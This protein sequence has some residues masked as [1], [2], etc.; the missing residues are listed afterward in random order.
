[1]RH[2]VV[3]ILAFFISVS[4]EAKASGGSK[5]S[6]GS[7]FSKLVRGLTRFGLGYGFTQ[8][9]EP[10]PT[11]VSDFKTPRH[12]W[13]EADFPIPVS[14]TLGF[15]EQWDDSVNVD[16]FGDGVK[17]GEIYMTNV[18]LG[19]KLTFPLYRIQPWAG[20]GVVG[21]LLTVSNPK[22]RNTHNWLVIFDKESR[23]VRG[24]YA[25]AGL[26]IFL[27]DEFG[28]RVGYRWEKIITDKFNNLNKT[29]MKFE[30]TALMVGLMGRIF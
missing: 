1:M 20:A 27:N 4:V 30:S 10:T 3:I 21:G 2:L 7:N 25:H 23:A 12:F 5:S 22:D 8:I 18:L 29:A 24:S 17:P 11:S 9:K 13:Q 19:M 14:V 16:F 15:R 28:L 26:D 6:T